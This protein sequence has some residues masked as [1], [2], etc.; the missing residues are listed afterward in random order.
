MSD[1]GRKED[2]DSDK[3]FVADAKVRRATQFGRAIDSR[4]LFGAEYEVAIRHGDQVYRLRKTR[5][6]KLILN[7]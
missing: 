7:K 3:T 1:R 6:G 4:I 5:N 2:L